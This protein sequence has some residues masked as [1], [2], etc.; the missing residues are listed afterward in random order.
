MQ[1]RATF[2]HNTFSCNTT[3]KPHRTRATKRDAEKGLYYRD[4]HHKSFEIHPLHQNP[5]RD[6]LA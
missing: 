3:G 4:I 5:S 2:S 6:K 1:R